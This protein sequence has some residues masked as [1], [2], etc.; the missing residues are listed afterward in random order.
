VTI[1]RTIAF[2]AVQCYSIAQITPAR[3]GKDCEIVFPAALLL[4]GLVLGF[5]IAAPVGPIGV[6]CIRRTL[7][8]G[9]LIGFVSGMGAATA[10]AVYGGVAGFGLT[11]ISSVLVDQQ[12]W[13]RIIGG[14]FLCYLG[15]RT[16]MADPANGG[17][18]A[19]NAE[20]T[21]GL[22]GAYV[23]TLFLTLTNPATI[24]SF[25]AIFAGFGVGSGDG[26]YLSAMLLVL[27]VFCGSAAWWLVL[28][29]GVSL[30]RERLGP[31]ILLWV[32]RLSGAIIL[33]FGVL[34]LASALMA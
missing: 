20:N 3:T 2:D 27:G 1:K 8:R 4:K 9:R 19:S 31:G 14:L 6:L 30:L 15:A 23:S 32:N 12:I 29:T 21:K 11:A 26:G 22:V 33:G 25:G 16:L 13:F 17:A 34:A 18:A 24:L 28:S 10:D 7:T 5:S